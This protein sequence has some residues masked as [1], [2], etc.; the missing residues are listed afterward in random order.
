MIQ[1][2]G[3]G[4]N[5]EIRREFFEGSASRLRIDGGHMGDGDHFLGNGSKRAQSIKLP[6]VRRVPTRDTRE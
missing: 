1:D 5:H 3:D 2:D 4:K 6:Y